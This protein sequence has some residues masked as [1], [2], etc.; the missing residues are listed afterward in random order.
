MENLIVQVEKRG[1]EGLQWLARCLLAIT[2][3]TCSGNK[4]GTK[5]A[6]IYRSD[7]MW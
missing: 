7:D 1:S 3:C 6:R 4:S 5:Q 2:P